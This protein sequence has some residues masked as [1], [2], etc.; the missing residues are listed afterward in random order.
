MQR[1][2]I[3]GTA[4]V[5]SLIY[6]AVTM[7]GTAYALYRVLFTD[8][9]QQISLPVRSFW[10][11]IPDGYDV[12]EGPT[13]EVV[14]GGFTHADVLIAGLGRDVSYWLAAGQLAQG[15]T[16]ILVGLAVFRMSSQLGQTA[17]FQPAM[18]RATK[19]A[20]IAIMVGGITWQAAFSTAGSIASQQTLRYTAWGSSGEVPPTVNGSSIDTPLG[21]G[22]T[23]DISVDFWPIGVGIALLVVAYAFRYGEKLQSTNARLRADSDGLV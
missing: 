8:Q 19:L 16:A 14:G 15:L 12:A 21:V 22:E 20:G 7:V 9:A 13:A 10:P 5:L 3:L 23:L 6:L 1:P 18:A 17:S 4:R 2:K 11:E